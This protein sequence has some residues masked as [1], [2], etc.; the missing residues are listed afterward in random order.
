M[1]YKKH[2]TN[3]TQHI[4]YKYAYYQN[5]HTYTYPHITK[6]VKTNTVHD[7]YKWNSHSIT[8]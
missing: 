4:K 7:I 1:K 8:K 6:Q 2:S 5:T 3:N